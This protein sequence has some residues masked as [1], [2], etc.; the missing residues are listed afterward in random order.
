[1][2]LHT[3]ILVSFLTALLALPCLSQEHSV[4]A[5]DASMVNITIQPGDLLEIYTF[6][7]PELTAKVRVEGD[8]SI[9]LPLIGRLHV[10]D[11]TPASA[12]HAIDEKLMQGQFL[13]DPHSS[14]FVKEYATQGVSVVGEVAKPGIYPMNGPR[15]L[16]D[17]LATLA[18]SVRMRRVKCVSSTA[19]PGKYLPR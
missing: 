14:V 12:A 15:K 7:V 16:L 9:E 11:A 5:R 18:G 17:L 2:R 1:M 8:G 4:P 19:V 6:D 10:S 13:R 3:A